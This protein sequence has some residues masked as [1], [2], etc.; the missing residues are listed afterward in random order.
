MAKALEWFGPDAKLEAITYSLPSGRTFQMLRP[1]HLNDDEF[2]VGRDVTLE[3]AVAIWTYHQ[4][5]AQ[6]K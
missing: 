1:T 3:E 2:Y 4:R 6:T 5:F